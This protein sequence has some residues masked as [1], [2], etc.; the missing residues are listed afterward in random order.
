MAFLWLPPCPAF[1]PLQ[2]NIRPP[3]VVRAVTATP[4]ATLLARCVPDVALL[5]LWLEVI[6]LKATLARQ[7]VTEVTRVLLEPLALSVPRAAAVAVLGLLPLGPEVH[8]TNFVTEESLSSVLSKS[9]SGVIKCWMFNTI[10]TSTV[11][12]TVK[13]SW[14]LFSLG[15]GQ[16]WNYSVWSDCT[17]EMKKVTESGWQGIKTRR[18]LFAVQGPLVNQALTGNGT[19]NTTCS[20][21]PP[22]LYCRL[23]RSAGATEGLFVLRGRNLSLDRHWLKSFTSQRRNT[24]GMND[25]HALFP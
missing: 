25:T 14:D 15:L 10:P 13:T 16:V 8:P 3:F 9:V 12:F 22:K 11:I 24:T 5:T 2:N 7:V 21:L 18:F 20:V 1:W 4:A 17:Y 6:L 19:P 23:L